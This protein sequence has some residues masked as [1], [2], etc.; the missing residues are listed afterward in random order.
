MGYRHYFHKCKKSDVAAIRDKTL[1]E[2]EV[3]A[4]EHNTELYVFSDKFLPKEKVFCFGKLY[5]EDTAERIY[6]TGTP[7]FSR[8]E[9]MEEFKDYIPYEVGKAGVLKAIEIYK[10]KIKAYYEQ[11][12]VDGATQILPF[13]IELP[14]PNVTSEQKIKEH[15]EEKLN[16]INRI[17]DTDINRKDVL[18]RS[19]EYEYSIFNLV[20]I[21]K[22]TDWEN[23][24]IIFLGW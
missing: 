17:V 4:K 14:L 24:T 12:T 10:E 6:G 15:I 19:W 22:T 3:Y 18:T 9:V 8:P 5:Y 2:L 7:M 21:L 16:E 13:G 11:L 1:E 20:Y 23:E